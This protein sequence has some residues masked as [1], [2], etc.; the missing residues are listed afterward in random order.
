MDNKF[1]KVYV[2]PLTH[3]RLPGPSFQPRE[4]YHIPS[5]I[6]PSFSHPA[7]TLS[8]HDHGHA[9]KETFI[10][11]QSH[12]TLRS[13]Y[14]WWT[15]AAQVSLVL[16]KSTLGPTQATMGHSITTGYR[17]PFLPALV[18]QTGCPQGSSSASTWTQPVLFHRCIPNGLGSQLARSSPLRTMVSPGFQSAHQL[19]GTRS[20][21]TSCSPMGTALDQSDSLR[22]L[23][24][25]YGSSAHTQAGRDLFHITIQQ[26]N[27]TLSSSIFL[28]SLGFYSSQLTSPE[29][30][31]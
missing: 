25:Q 14:P 13:F 23:R 21:S 28:T 9:C 30:G 31:I 5:R 7:P 19:A 16:D 1:E 24:Q 6:I 11:H 22:L 17:I 8:V 26:N 10:H 15:P 12:F 3:S 2:D 29:P 4:S 18:Q 20:H 27:G